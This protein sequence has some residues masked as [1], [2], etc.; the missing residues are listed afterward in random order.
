MWLYQTERLSTFHYLKERSDFET[1]IEF[2]NN[3]KNSNKDK[4]DYRFKLVFP[5]YVYLLS[6]L[7][8]MYLSAEEWGQ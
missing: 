2:E 3:E 7:K 4:V 6:N 1:E 5:T 8:I